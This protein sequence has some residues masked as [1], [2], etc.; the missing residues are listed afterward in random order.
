MYFRRTA[1]KDIKIRAKVGYFK[2]SFSRNPSGLPKE[3]KGGGIMK[4]KGKFVKVMDGIAE[5]TETMRYLFL[6]FLIIIVYVEF[7]SPVLTWSRWI[8]TPAFV[9]TMVGWIWSSLRAGFIDKKKIK[10]RRLKNA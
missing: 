6:G 1:K 4:E 3:K 5:I 8:I 2:E 10:G 7:V 9:L